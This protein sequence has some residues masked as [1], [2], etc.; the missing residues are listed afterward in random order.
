MSVQT[1]IDRI[2]AAVGAAYDAVEQKGGTVPQSETVAGLA[3]AIG[4]I[5]T[6]GSGE[7][8]ELITSGEMAEAAALTITKDADGAALSLK[9]AQIIVDGATSMAK[10]TSLRF[11][12]D[13]RTD[14]RNSEEWTV[15]LAGDNK[16]D[17]ANIRAVYIAEQNKIPI[18][19]AEL[20]ANSASWGTNV[21]KVQAPKKRTKVDNVSTYSF[22]PLTATINRIYVGNHMGNGILG[23][24]CKYQIWG[25]R[26]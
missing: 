24:G 23:V 14:V 22:D 15:E 7:N 13:N 25:V 5:P 16:T 18:L 12:V 8:W 11:E 2:T 20:P 17:N 19:Y 1:E 10:S 9:S 3:E 6:G 21:S 4:S 26:A